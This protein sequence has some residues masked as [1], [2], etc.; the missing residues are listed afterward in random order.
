MHY[1][2]LP[3]DEEQLRLAALRGYALLDTPPEAAFDRLAALAARIFDVPL[4]LVSLID[5]ERQW[6][7]ACQGPAGADLTL[8]ET[9]R[10]VAF[11]AHTILAADVLV[12][13]DARLD[14]R[15]ADNPFVL[16]EPH[17]RFYAGA[18]LLT[19]EGQA[20]GSLCLIDFQPREFSSAQREALRDLA[21]SVVSEME[22][23]SASAQLA[24][25]GQ[26]YQ[27]VFAGS[28]LP[29]WVF[30]VETLRFLDVNETAIAHYGYSRDEFLGM[31][32]VDI[33]L[34]EDLPA[35]WSANPGYGLQPGEKLLRRH[36]KKDGGLIWVEVAVHD[37]D[38]HG[39]AARMAVINDITERRQAEDASQQSQRLAQNTLDGLTFHITILD[40][41]GNILA[42][43]DAWR[44]FAEANG[45]CC[46]TPA[47]L[48][49][50]YAGQNYLQVCE[51]VQGKDSAE[52]MQVAEGIGRVLRGE[53]EFFTLEYPC[54]APWEQ[55]WFNLR[56]TRFAGDGPARVVVAHENITERYLTEQ[57]RRQLEQKL[58]LHIQQT[59]LA[60]IEVNQ[61]FEVTAWNP[62]AEKLF[63]YSCAEAMG[64]HSMLLLATE[65]DR[66]R[67]D[68]MSRSLLMQQGGRSSTS[69]NQ[70]KS[71]EIILCE[72]HNTP[73]VD[74]AGKVIGFVA[75]ARDITEESRVQEQLQESRERYKSLVEHHPF[76]VCSIDLNGRFLSV[77]AAF[78]DL[79]GLPNSEVQGQPCGPLVAPECLAQA[80]WHYTQTLQGWS[81]T[82][83][84][85]ILH[86]EGRRIETSITTAPLFTGGAITGI[87]AVIQDVSSQKALEAE[88]EELLAQTESLLADALER[89]DLDTLTGL[90]NHRAFHKRLEDELARAEQKGRPLSLILMDL[91]N[92]K[93]FND[94]YGHLVGD[95][96]LRQVAQALNACGGVGDTLARFG[97]DEFVLLMPGATRADALRVAGEMREAISHLGYSPPGYDV[98]IPLTLSVGA[99]CVADDGPARVDVLEAADA[100]LRVAKS[101]GEDAGQALRL[102]QDIAR[103]V[104]GF[105]MLDALVTAVDN[106]DRY[107]RKHSEDVMN[108][109][110]QIACALRLD[111]K[112][113]HTVE[114]AA[115][116]HDVGKIGVPDAILRKPGKLSEEDFKAI[117]QHPM[118]GA[119]I[120]GAVPGFEETVD[121]VR[122]HHERWDGEGYPLGL[123][124][125]ETPL[126]A[127]L[128]A[129]ADAYSAMTTDRPYR[130][131]MARAKARRILEQGAGTQWDPACVAAFLQFGSG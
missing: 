124:G 107:T 127:R 81:Q 111:Q 36:C 83:E 24:E 5:Q 44:T 82:H 116:L 4:A 109:S 18:P 3:A 97:G 86:R 40:A 57:A 126:L 52:A 54:H 96:V 19:A 55:R 62:A 1:P 80:H 120:V 46:P 39:C 11:C 26:V 72:W 99:A 64:Q 123:R 94:V 113:R 91:D 53:R 20:V 50:A 118:M 78:E 58:S 27:K 7:K 59:P 106:K 76:A 110:V 115:L 112:T 68:Q 70:T 85:V 29:M 77:N 105:S 30:D 103:S 42:V 74:D 93:F 45:C 104:Q 71:S 6:F 15:F 61:D 114:I 84:L 47:G 92:F 130:K 119:A 100:R 117:K 41:A 25:S 125:E 73:L 17:L 14:S 13:E 31:T 9:P 23:R 121:A 35:F 95:D 69:R 129:V 32:L 79:L 12:A 2:S 48:C 122:H 90:M 10:D 131:G 128:M 33:R 89:A 66:E 102:R 37:I 60:V 8:S 43:N 21:A 63:G 75:L 56:V 28:P 98:P 101:G 88:R 49:S 16:G 87:Y 65:A 51:Q 108:Y 22:L 67:V 34:P 38:Y